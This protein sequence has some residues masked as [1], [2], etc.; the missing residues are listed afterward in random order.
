MLRSETIEPEKLQAIFDAFSELPYTVL[1][2]AKREKFPDGLKIP[3]NIH[4]Q[5]WM[6]QLD[7]LCKIVPT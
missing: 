6:P 1:W 2:K 4:F 7:I 3:S 5:E